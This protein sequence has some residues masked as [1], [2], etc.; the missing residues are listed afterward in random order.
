MRVLSLRLIRLFALGFGKSKD[1]FDAW[2]EKECSCE[3]RFIHYKPREE[4]TKEQLSE[5]HF[6]L[7][8]PEHSDSGFI[9]LLSTFGYPGL[10][11]EIEGEYRSIQPVDNAIVV[12]LGRTLSKISGEKYKATMHRVL[13][14]GR[15]R[16]SSPFFM[17]P[18]FSARL[19]DDLL[20]SAR[21]TCEDPLYEAQ[22]PQEMAQLDNFGDFLQKRMTSAYVEWKGFQIRPTTYDYSSRP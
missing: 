17:N 2:F 8:T 18:K 12:N 5:E 11:V 10:Q 13:D 9:T 21:S 22:H 4:S 1:Y 14:I 20:Q 16:Y 7:V 15:E 3:A 6:K 19:S